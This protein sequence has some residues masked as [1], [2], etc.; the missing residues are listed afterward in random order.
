MEKKKLPVKSKLLS[1]CFAVFFF[2][3]A[4]AP[5]SRETFKLHGLIGYTKPHGQLD[6]GY[7]D[8]LMFRLNQF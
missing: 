2:A 6:Y 4:S 7:L 1:L 8:G 3:V 5:V